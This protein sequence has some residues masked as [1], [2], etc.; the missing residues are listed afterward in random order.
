[1]CWVFDMAPVSVTPTANVAGHVQMYPLAGQ[2]PGWTAIG[3]LVVRPEKHDHGIARYLLRESVRH[4]REAGGTPVLDL[5]TCL[6]RS[7]ELFRRCGFESLPD[8]RGTGSL[9]VHRG[10]VSRA[11]SRT[12]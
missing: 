1:M 9:L 5:D 11:R 3:Q 10:E 6:F 2:D 4:V 7:E 12:A 8:S